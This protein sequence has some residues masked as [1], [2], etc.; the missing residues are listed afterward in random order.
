MKKASAPVIGAFVVGATVLGVAALVILGGG[1]LFARTHTFVAYFRGSVQGL[2]VGAPVK[3]KGVD[4]GSVSE[5]RINISRAPVDGKD[6][7]IP[8]LISLDERKIAGGGARVDFDDPATVERYIGW[9]LRA[10]LGTASLITGLRYVALD[11]FPGSPAERVG[12]PTVSYTEIPSLPGELEGAQREVLDVLAR[13]SKLDLEH[14]MG[15][16]TGTLQSIGR[17]ADSAD[18][19]V[20]DLDRFARMPEL[21]Q[22]IKNVRD[23]TAGLRATIDGGSIQTLAATAQRALDRAGTVVGP[24]SRILGQVEQTLADVAGAARSLRRLADQLDRD[25]AALLRGRSP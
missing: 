2:D 4:I 5:V 12:D 6:L 3:F 19:L 11:I 20:A 18:R 24:D 22:A 13:L 8:V 9:G 10:Q 1:R 16:L 23:V 21:P 7:R 17:A 15:T 14:L 25:P